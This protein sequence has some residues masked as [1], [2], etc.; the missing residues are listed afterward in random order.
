MCSCPSPHYDLQLIQ[1]LVRSR[2]YSPTGQALVDLGALGFEILDLEQC[3]LA[4]TQAD[5]YKTMPSE[6]I[7]DR[8]Q[9]VYRPTYCGQPL[10][11]KLQV[12]ELNHSRKRAVIVSFKRK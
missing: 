11:V 2:Q 12:V 9:D 7:S 1:Q 6:K 5:F 4:L 10:Y 3:I 8:W